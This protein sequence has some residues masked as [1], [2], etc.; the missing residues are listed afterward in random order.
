MH[1]NAQRE[2]KQ[3]TRQLRPIYSSLCVWQQCKPDKYERLTENKESRAEGLVLRE[4]WIP[5]MHL[6]HIHPHPLHTVY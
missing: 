4:Q 6:N 3:K 2:G 5:L 1:L